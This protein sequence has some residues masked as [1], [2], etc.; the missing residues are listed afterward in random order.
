M[1]SPLD[2]ASTASSS[3][4]AF[5]DTLYESQIPQATTVAVSTERV[6]HSTWLQWLGYGLFSMARAVPGALVW[7]IAFATITLPAFLFNLAST[8][9]TFTMNATTLYVSA[10]RVP[11][12]S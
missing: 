8:S 11:G 9:L 1:A 3:L 10:S 12:S 5:L 7:I 6:A 4:T 2:E